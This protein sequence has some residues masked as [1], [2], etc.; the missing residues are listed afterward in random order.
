VALTR[1]IPELQLEVGDRLEPSSELP[2]VS[3]LDDVSHFPMQV[4]FWRRSLESL[5]RHRSPLF[6]AAT[7]LDPVSCIT[8]DWMHALNLGVMKGFVKHVVWVLLSNKIWSR[9]GTLE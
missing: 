7:G 6:C 8:V 9:V 1:D 4:V 2:V 5:C 3:K